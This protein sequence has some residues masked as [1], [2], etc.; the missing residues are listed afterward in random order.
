MA[1]PVAGR[2]VGLYVKPETA[3][4]RGLPKRSVGEIEFRESG[5][6]GDFN[7][8]RTEERHGDPAMAV[9]LI[10]SEL[11]AEL[12]REGWPVRPGDLGEN[13]TTE[14]IDYARLGH[15]RWRIGTA[16]V[17]ISKACDPCDT[18]RLLP[19]VGSEKLAGFLRT[20]LG[21]R[22][23]YARVVTPG[24]AR[25]GDLVESRDSVPTVARPWAKAV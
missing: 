9:L 14:G 7:R 17:E 12:R 25:L 10:S 20:M 18:L 11:L 2:V 22:G 1:A 4:E 13:V 6:V 8:F 3:G 23:W 19:Y 16:E 24:R 21:R 5:V 15:G